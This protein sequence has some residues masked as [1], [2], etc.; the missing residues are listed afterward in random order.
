MQVQR[1]LSQQD[2]RH[3]AEMCL[4]TMKTF[5]YFDSI[6]VISVVHLVV[7]FLTHIFSASQTFPFITLLSRHSSPCPSLCFTLLSQLFTSKV[8][9]LWH[10]WDYV[11]ARDEIKER[12]FICD[13]TKTGDVTENG[14]M[15]IV[16]R[17]NA[18]RCN[19]N[20]HHQHKPLNLFA[21]EFWDTKMYTQIEAVATQWKSLCW[22][23]KGNE[24]QWQIT[25]VMFFHYMT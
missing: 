4:K 8:S 21:F 24:I 12:D 3:S 14:R 9:I 7:V 18:L 11:H 13:R 23:L 16:R 20:V 5:I 10:G 22:F 2:C 1:A 19:E 6:V 25:I 17:R 15:T